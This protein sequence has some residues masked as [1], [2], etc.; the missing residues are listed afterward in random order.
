MDF[1]DYV[2]SSE[3]RTKHDLKTSHWRFHKRIENWKK[4]GQPVMSHYFWWFVHNCVAHPMIGVAPTKA[5]FA[6]HDFTSDK[7]NGK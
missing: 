4:A 7:I 6:F 2:P 5:T 1:D 3:I